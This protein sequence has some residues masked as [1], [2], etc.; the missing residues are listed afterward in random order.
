LQVSGSVSTSGISLCAFNLAGSGTIQNDTLPLAYSGTTCLGPVSGTETLRKG[1][2]GTPAA[3]NAPTPVSP[4]G[5]VSSTQPTLVVTNATRTGSGGPLAYTFQVTQDSSFN[6]NVL[7]WNVPEGSG[8]TSLIVPQALNGSAT[9]FWRARAYDGGLNGAW[10]SASTF[11]TPGT[12]TPPSPGNAAGD[13]LDMSRAV[14]ENS[15]WDLASYAVTT[16]LQV[17]NIRPDGF[18]VEFSKKDGPGRWPDVTPPGWTGPLQYTLGMCLWI[19]NQWYCS[20]VVEYWY[21]LQVSGGPPGDVS[22]NWFYDQIRWGPMT[23]RQPA[24]G[25][26]VGIFVCEGDCRNNTS[27]SLSPL[28]ERSNVVLIKYPSSAG[29]VFRF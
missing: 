29:G 2:P 23:G 11:T 16:S 3:I 19:N 6:A 14:I 20:A 24:V 12:P 5:S 10:S 22:V 9:Y 13:Q 17:V 7:S 25:E 26:T 21:G 8:Q 28:R 15:P 27:G 18:L 1:I 4:S